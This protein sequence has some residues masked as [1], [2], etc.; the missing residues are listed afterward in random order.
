MCKQ[1]N[2]RNVIGYD[3][4]GIS[5]AVVRLCFLLTH[6]LDWTGSFAES[7]GEIRFPEITTPVLEK[8]IQYFYYKRRYQ[9]SR[10][11]IPEFHI[12]PEIALELLMAANYLDV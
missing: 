2:Q 8:V 1:H 9:N 7:Q 11:P 12:E 3:W 6:H 4:R 10:V 5:S